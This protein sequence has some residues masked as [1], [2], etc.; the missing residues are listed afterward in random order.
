MPES[1]ARIT[2]G[3]AVAVTRGGRSVTGGEKAEHSFSFT[4]AQRTHSGRTSARGVQAGSRTIRAWRPR[5]SRHGELAIQ[6]PPR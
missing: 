6:V 3:H 2:T 1:H 4:G 5:E